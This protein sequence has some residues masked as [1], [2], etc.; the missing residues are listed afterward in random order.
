VTCPACA[1]QNRPGAKFCEACAA[2]LQRLCARCGVELRPTARFC[3]ECGTPVAGG[4]AQPVSARKVLTIVFADLVGS[5]ALHERLDSEAARLFMERYYAAMRGAVEAHGGTVAKLMGDGVMAVFGA[6]RVAEDDAIRAVRAAAAMQDAFLT[7]AQQQSALVGAIG[8]RVGVNTGEIVADE[9]SELIGDPVN[10]AAR[11]QQEAGDGNVVIGE[12]THRLIATLVTL[13]PLGSLTVKGR[14]EAVKAYRLVS[15]ERPE[16]RPGTRRPRAGG[17][18]ARPQAPCTVAMGCSSR[19][20]RCCARRT[21]RCATNPS[22]SSASTCPSCANRPR[23]AA[24]RAA[25][26]TS[27]P[28]NARRSLSPRATRGA[29]RSKRVFRPRISRPRHRAPVRMARRVAAG[30]PGAHASRRDRPLDG[31]SLLRDP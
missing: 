1:H 22:P 13:A 30:R 16:P 5:T 18:P 7:L 27:R 17:G 26:S 31:E 2:P 25:A 10:V 21:R 12:A 14:G 6:P 4:P 3:D 8:L 23:R 19:C 24:R 11:L 29:A 28:S 20:G 9:Q 15:L